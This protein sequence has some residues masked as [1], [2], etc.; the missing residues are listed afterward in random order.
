[1]H[2]S[3]LATHPLKSAAAVPLDRLRL[4][5]L[6][7][8]WDRRWM[9]VDGEGAF[10]TQRTHPRMCLLVAQVQDGRLRLRAPGLPELVVVPVASPPAAPVRVWRDT[11]E[12]ELPSPEADA[13]CSAFLGLPV[14]LA[15]LPPRAVRPVDPAWA[16]EGHRTAFSDGF[17]LLVTTQSSL[18]HLNR[19]LLADGLPAVDW[20]R[21]RPNLVVAGHLPPHAE[22]GWRRLRVGTVELELVKP[23]SRCVIPSIDPDT[24][25]KDPR[26]LQVLR[27]YRAREDGFLYLGQNAVVAAAPDDSSIRLQDRVEVLV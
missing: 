24:A 12:A 11:V 25:C 15:Y 21:F 7:P 13:W 19:L 16:G 9:L 26:I 22:D 18:D 20:R 23:C 6:G 1:M 27:R 2:V 17:P 14:R 8:E 10:V 5:D 4:T 3:Y